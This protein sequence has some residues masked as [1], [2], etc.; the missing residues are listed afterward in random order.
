MAAAHVLKFLSCCTAGLIFS[1]V[2]LMLLGKGS[3]F[4]CST[5]PPY[6]NFHGRAQCCPLTYVRVCV[7]LF[8]CAC[9]CKCP[10]ACA[11]VLLCARVLVLG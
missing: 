10:R 7:C 1:I 6:A 11:Y 3:S 8:V 5:L 9:L 2:V 4:L